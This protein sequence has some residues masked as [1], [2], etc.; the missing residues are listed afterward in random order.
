MDLSISPTKSR[1]RQRTDNPIGSLVAVIR[2]NPRATQQEHI[3][4]FKQ[5]LRLGLLDDYGDYADAVVD[6]WCRIKYSTAYAA[7][8]P[9]TPQQIKRRRR[10][11]LAR[12]KAQRAAFD[13]ARV[14]IV[15]K[16]LERVMPNG[17]ALGDCTG[18]ECVAFGGWLTKV[19]EIVGD[20]LV[21]DVL[22]NRQVIKLAARRNEPAEK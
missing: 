21:K 1:S 22:S 14:A 12:Q 10:E 17:K 2:E 3:A 9:P 4:A 6:E 15:G 13:R 8:V 18:V 19:G 5:I 16:A 11:R 7:A 20:R